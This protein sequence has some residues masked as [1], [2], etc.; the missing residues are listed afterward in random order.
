[1]PR[2]GVFFNTLRRAFGD[3]VCPIEQEPADKIQG[4][5]LTVDGLEGK[6][7]AA[8][9][10]LRWMDQT[11]TNPLTRAPLKVEMLHPVMTRHTNL[12]EYTQMVGSLARRGW[13]NAAN[14]AAIPEVEEDLRQRG[15]AKRTRQSQRVADPI[16]AV[17][18]GLQQHWWW[19]YSRSAN[20]R[21][22]LR[23]LDQI[24]LQAVFE[25][26]AHHSVGMTER[27]EAFLWYRKSLW[28]FPDGEPT[29]PIYL[30]PRELSEDF[31][32][33]YPAD[34]ARFGLRY[35]QQMLEEVALDTQDRNN[36]YIDDHEVARYNGRMTL[37][38][39][40]PTRTEWFLKVILPDEVANNPERWRRPQ[41]RR[42]IAD[43]LWTLLFSA[44]AVQRRMDVWHV[45]KLLERFMTRTEEN[46]LR[47]YSMPNRLPTLLVNEAGLDARLHEALTRC[48]EDRYASRLFKPA[49]AFVPEIRAR[50]PM[51]EEG[52]QARVSDEEI[53][54]AVERF[55]DYCVD[56]GYYLSEEN[57]RRVVYDHQLGPCNPYQ[58]PRLLRALQH[59]MEGDGPIYE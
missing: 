31:M 14:E 55:F 57:L 32:A 35:V 20:K 6:P 9:S 33:L 56:S 45:E 4:G 59:G 26:T 53:C 18:R 22:A 15:G 44:S 47:F 51:E 38:L 12:E 34:T 19:V 48:I 54:A 43:R 23:R 21:E 5:I 39:Y 37:I 25:R 42:C 58:T 36:V 13:W 52:G 17:H 46:T 49:M 24:Q 41:E 29:F 50:L 3:E 16:R 7:F 30:D 10:L 28:R 8:R 40:A 11:G 2:T 1:M 27:L